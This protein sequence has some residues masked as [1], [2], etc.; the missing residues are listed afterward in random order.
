MQVKEKLNRW[1]Y[2]MAALCEPKEVYFCNGSE[3]EYLKLSQEAVAKGAL[4]KLNE[5]KRPGCFYARSVP[6]DVA[7]MEDRTFVCSSTEE[8]AGPTNNW[9]EPAKMKETLKS[10]FQ[11][12]MRGRTMYVIPFS[13]GPIGSDKAH[14]GVELTDSIYVVLNMRIM[15]RMGKAV[16]DALEEKGNFVRCLHS[17]G[18]PLLP[19]MTDV[20]WPSNP[21]HKY[22]VHFPAEKE[23]WSFGSGYGGNALLGK[24]CFSLRIA[25][26]MAREEGWLAEHMLIL[27]I[28]P[29]GGKKVYVAGAFPSACGKTN[30]AMMIPGLPG[31]K[32]E[33]VGDDIAWMKFGKDGRLYAINPETG[34]FGVAPGTSMKS[35]PNIMKTIEKNTIFTNVALTS[36]GDVW[37]E[38]MTEEP[39]DNLI[40]WQGKSWTPRCGRLAAHPN[41]RFTTPATQCPVIDPAW[42]DPQGVP[43]SAILFGGRRSS[44]V[45]LVYEAFDWQH[46]VF[47]GSTMASET[48]AAITGT[49]GNLRRDPFAMLP[50]CGYHMGDYFTHWLEMGRKSEPSLLPKIFYV[51]WFRKSPSGKWLWP[52][53]GENARVLK[54]VLERIEGLGK[55][56]ETAIGYVPTDDALDL[57]GLNITKETMKELLKVDTGEWQEELSSLKKH[58]QLFGD[59]LPLALWKEYEAL[60][61]RLGVNLR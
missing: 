34:F 6:D 31:W 8:E 14:I 29:P 4:L 50:F 58:L 40:D 57:S 38:E 2:E 11:G 19:G 60:A 24:K 10:L 33:C 35:N 23:I 49:V 9:E 59:R 25:S 18:M 48:T 39:P 3:E 15:T 12:S 1:V 16:L 44:V 17:V 5:V 13:M 56:K 26:V 47:L 53:Y 7:R 55:A 43:I 61:K 28:T 45:P 27:G 21:D 22:I 37:W 46:G 42:E 36:D 20:S 32:V 54:W 41:A 30:L 52:G 51:N